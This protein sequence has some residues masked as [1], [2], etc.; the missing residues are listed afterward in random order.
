MPTLTFEGETHGEI[1]VKVAAAGINRPD[2][3]QRQGH[4]PPPPGASAHL[5]LPCS[6]K[7]MTRLTPIHAG[8]WVRQWKPVW[9]RWRKR[10]SSVANLGEAERRFSMRSSIS[11]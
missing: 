10:S 5:T 2:V 1:L 8:R 11:G 4:Y 9:R 6:K 7:T 3:L